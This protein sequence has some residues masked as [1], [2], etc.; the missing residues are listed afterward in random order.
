MH[1]RSALSA[2]RLRAEPSIQLVLPVGDDGNTMSWL[3]YR[4]CGFSTGCS[5][6]EPPR[7]RQDGVAKM[8]ELRQNYPNKI[9][10]R[11][12]KLEAA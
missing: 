1:S 9:I 11:C 3:R 6:K 12:L 8:G 5:L 10:M 4:S 7:G 2:I